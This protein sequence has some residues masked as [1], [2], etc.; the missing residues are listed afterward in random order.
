MLSLSN[1]AASSNA[2]LRRINPLVRTQLR[3]AARGLAGASWQVPTQLV[4]TAAT[5]ATPSGVN[6]SASVSSLGYSGTIAHAVAR[7]STPDG[8][9]SLLTAAQQAVT[10]PSLRY[11]RCPFAWR[12]SRSTPGTASGLHQYKVPWQRQTL[13][14]LN[15]SSVGAG[16]RL[17]IRSQVMRAGQQVA[18]SGVPLSATTTKTT[19][20]LLAS[21]DG[22]HFLTAGVEALAA[23]AAVGIP[24]LI[25]TQGIQHPSTLAP[26]QTSTHAA[27]HG[28]LWGATRV[29]RLELAWIVRIWD[30]PPPAHAVHGHGMRGWRL[31]LIHI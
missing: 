14:H 20:I 16:K 27:A 13:L 29:V 4:T 25:L 26:L 15:L 1:E 17:L 11:R 30:A 24:A 8:T 6:C 18:C 10:T 7:L 5:A 3:E 21:S 22:M 28:G 9:T 12:S 2:Q 23:L 19:A 31:S